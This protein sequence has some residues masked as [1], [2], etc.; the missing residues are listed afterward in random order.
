MND[1]ERELLRLVCDGDIRKA[2]LQARI[3]LNGIC[4][5]KDESFKQ[6]N[7]R[8]L[9]A[10]GPSLI[11]LPH[12]L[13]ELLV[14][15]DVTEF[16]EERFVL[17]DN[18]RTAVKKVLSLYRVSAKL[19]EMGI[20]YLP[21]LLLYGES[22]CGKTMLA[23]YI[24]HKAELPFL[25]VRFSNVVSSYL[26]STQSNIGKI[27]EYARTSPCVLCFDEIDA[28]GMSRGQKN[29]VG[30]MNRIVIALMQELDQLR[31]NSIIVGTTNRFDRLDAALIRRFPLQ[32]EITPLNFSE[33]E[34][35]ARKFFLYAGVNCLEWVGPWCIKNFN[36]LEAASSVV[37]KCTDVI[38][39]KLIEPD[40]FSTLNDV[41]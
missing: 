20:S 33:I 22:G 21:A 3:I 26:G 14:A 11:E 27:F 31:N 41:F 13:R 19:A 5:K 2:Q 18:E 1:S 16:P 10:K 28:V 32:Y 12:N 4:A 35:L 29:D 8:K 17:R 40:D 25:Y 38:V 34:N 37:K 9:D 30:E 23:R 39:Q 6:N 15:E 7:L 24:A 36:E